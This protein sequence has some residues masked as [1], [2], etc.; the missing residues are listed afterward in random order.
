[1]EQSRL[2]KILEWMKAFLKKLEGTQD[3]EQEWRRWEYR[4]YKQYH[5]TA[6]EMDNGRFY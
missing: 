1:M 5:A 4:E 2:K 3:A 6:R